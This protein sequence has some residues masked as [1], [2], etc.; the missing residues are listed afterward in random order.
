[1][2]PLAGLLV[3]APAEPGARFRPH[4]IPAHSSGSARPCGSRSR[5]AARS[6][7]PPRGSTARSRLTA[8]RPG[9]AVTGGLAGL[10]KTASHEWPEVSCKSLDLPPD[11]RSTA[12]RASIGRADCRRVAASRPGR[13]RPVDRRPVRAATGPARRS[14]AKS[15][16]RRCRTGTGRRHRRCARRHRRRLRRHRQDVW[17]QPSAPRPQ[18]RADARAAMAR[19]VHGES[20]IKKAA[21][22]PRRRYVAHACWKNAT[23]AR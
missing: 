9:D 10:V 14:M 7:P 22:L 4:R 13:S 6:S 15:V 1:M 5:T 20:Q 16:N 11:A 17:L 19:G 23:A 18:P 2:G 12:N 8:T 21:G 3:L